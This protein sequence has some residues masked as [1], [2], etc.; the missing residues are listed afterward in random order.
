MTKFDWLFFIVFINPLTNS[1]YGRR[2]VRYSVLL[3]ILSPPLLFVT[4]VPWFPKVCFTDPK[5]SLTSFQGIRDYISVMA[6]L[7]FIYVL[8]VQEYCFVKNYGGRGARGG[9]VG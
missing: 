9:A 4:V 2:L 5:G 8:K 6:A 1:R 3:R 7:K